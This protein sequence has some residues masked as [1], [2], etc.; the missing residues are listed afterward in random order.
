T[1][2]VKT[3]FM[4]VMGVSQIP[5]SSTGTVNWND[6]KLRV[7]L[8]LDNTGS[9]TDNN[10]IGALKTATHNLLHQLQTAAQTDGD[11]YVSIV[12]FVKDINVGAGNYQQA[13]IDWTSWDQ[14][15]GTCSSS[16]YTTYNSCISHSRTW[17]PKNHNTWNGCVTD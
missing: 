4:N 2:T 14:A 15:N 6:G 3:N 9:M 8:V 12:P 10:K 16:S 13:W 7:A 1:A 5:V 17:T 11:V